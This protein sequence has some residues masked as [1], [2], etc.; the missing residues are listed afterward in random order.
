VWLAQE[1]P[2]PPSILRKPGPQECLM[3]GGVP[4]V[5]SRVQDDQPATD[6][7]HLPSALAGDGPAQT[8]LPIEGRERLVHIDQLGLDLDYQQVTPLPV[9]SQLID[10]AP[11][12]VDREGDLGLDDPT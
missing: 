8:Q 3:L 9:Q 12:P 1:W 6:P 4:P 11:L 2:K 7:V 10:R 5:R